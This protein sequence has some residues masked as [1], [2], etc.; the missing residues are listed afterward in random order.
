[1]PKEQFREAD[2]KKKISHVSFTIDS[3]HQIQQSSHLHV[4]LKS[5]YNQDQK[6]TPVA[7]GVLDLRLGVSQKNAVCETCNHGLNE[8]VGH[9]GYLDLALPVFHIGHFRATITILQTICKTCSRVM[10]KEDDAKMFSKRLTNP[11]LSYLAKKAIHQQVFHHP[12]SLIP[13]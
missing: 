5:L 9:F 10:L 11:N 7:H 4:K 6:R 8:C 12:L 1:M 13:I 3:S 2:V